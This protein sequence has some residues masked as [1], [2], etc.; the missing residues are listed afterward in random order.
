M[1]LSVRIHYGKRSVALIVFGSLVGAWAIAIIGAALLFG[2]PHVI[3]DCTLGGRAGSV[4]C[5]GLTQALGIALEIFFPMGMFLLVATPFWIGAGVVVA[6]V[7]AKR[8]KAST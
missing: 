5:G 7:E 3:P 6:L 1:A 4:Q 2:L 8:D